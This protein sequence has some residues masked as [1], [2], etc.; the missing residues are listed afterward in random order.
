MIFLPGQQLA[1]KSSDFIREI[2]TVRAHKA[3]GL[4]VTIKLASYALPDP[5][6]IAQRLIDTQELLVVSNVQLEELIQKGT[7]IPL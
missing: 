6:L 2:I 5:K 1:S 4:E 7:F 3:K